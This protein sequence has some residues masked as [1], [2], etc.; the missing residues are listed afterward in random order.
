MPDTKC[1]MIIRTFNAINRFSRCVSPW[2]H[3]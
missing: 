2:R 3:T 1:K